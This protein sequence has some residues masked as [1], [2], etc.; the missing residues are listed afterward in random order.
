MVNIVQVWLEYFPKVLPVFLVWFC[1]LLSSALLSIAALNRT[2]LRCV[3][4]AS[5]GYLPFVTL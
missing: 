3:D 5:M 1:D 2:P 4:I